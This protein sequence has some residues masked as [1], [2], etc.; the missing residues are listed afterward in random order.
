[1]AMTPRQTEIIKS[2]AGVLSEHA[3]TVATRFYRRLFEH[4]SELRN[5][6]NHANQ[7]SGGQSEARAHG[8]GLR[9]QHR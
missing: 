9:L 1:M 7:R 4:H 2:S 6:F 5:L 8:L 3:M